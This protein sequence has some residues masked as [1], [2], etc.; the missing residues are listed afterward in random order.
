MERENKRKAQKGPRGSR[1]EGSVG[2][3]R[4]GK[5]WHAKKGRADMPILS[6]LAKVIWTR[7]CATIVRVVGT[8]AG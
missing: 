1:T 8:R 4:S 5:L 7:A 2:E 3:W 6:V